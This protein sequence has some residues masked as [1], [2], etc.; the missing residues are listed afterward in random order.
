[1]VAPTSSHPSYRLSTAEPVTTKVQFLS[2]FNLSL[3]SGGYRQ[4]AMEDDEDEAQNDEREAG[5]AC[6][7]QISIKD[8]VATN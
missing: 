2:S 3:F 8:R 5:R 4:E 6:V 1:M 7:R